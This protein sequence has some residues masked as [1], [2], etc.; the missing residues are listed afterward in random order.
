MN[1]IEELRTRIAEIEIRHETLGIIVNALLG[2]IPDMKPLLIALET[3]TELHDA[4]ALYAIS[5]SGDQRQRVLAHLK[6][7]VDSL[8]QNPLLKPGA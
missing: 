2:L 5:L 6:G 3:A 4:N 1:E 7:F 8:K